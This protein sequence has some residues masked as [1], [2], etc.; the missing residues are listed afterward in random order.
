MN[1]TEAAHKTGLSTKTV[2]RMLD[3]GKIRGKTVGP[4]MVVIHE[5]D[6]IRAGLLPDPVGW[7]CPKCKTVH[8]PFTKTCGCQKGR[9]A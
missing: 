8:S 9:K 1:I 4:R 7:M 2:R 5:A 3:R 6:L